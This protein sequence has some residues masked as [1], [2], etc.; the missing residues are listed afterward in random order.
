MGGGVW[1]QAESLLMT[2]PGKPGTKDSADQFLLTHDTGQD[3]KD[4][5]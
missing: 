4:K 5:Y 2:Y 1:V 3:P